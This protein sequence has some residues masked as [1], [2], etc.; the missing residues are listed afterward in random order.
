MFKKPQKRIQLAPGVNSA[1]TD[2]TALHQAELLSCCCGRFIASH[3]NVFAARVATFLGQHIA[4]NLSVAS[5]CRPVNGA[6][7][8]Q[9]ISF[10][11]IRHA[12]WPSQI[13]NRS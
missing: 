1:A 3:E 11:E 10:L 5:R 12:N 8:K 2:A 9:V 6:V 7:R 13:H 4:G